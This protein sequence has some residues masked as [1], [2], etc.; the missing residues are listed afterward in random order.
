MLE[1]LWSPVAV[2]TS[3]HGGRANG[4]ITATAVTATLLPEA[5]RISV[6]LARASLTHELVL[7][8]GVFALHLLP[9][10]PLD[11]SLATFRALGFSSGRTAD[12]LAE[13]PWHSGRSGAPVLDTALAYVEARVSA[14][15][16]ADEV[17]VVVAV[18]VTGARL[19]PG[20]HLTIEHVR[21]HLTDEELAAWQA[22]SEEELA[23]ARRL[24][25]AD[26]S[27]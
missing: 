22:R 10:E 26:G 8:S 20:P 4:L 12:K 1:E 5:P 13:I 25:A 6:V 3:A 16:A 11:P 7:A 21:A 2:L 9:A 18:V 14:T 23:D 15:L 24:R 27:E 19:R 17:T